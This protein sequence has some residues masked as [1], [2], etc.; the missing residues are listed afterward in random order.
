MEAEEL[1]KE[2]QSSEELLVPSITEA[3]VPTMKGLLRHVV[4]LKT[5][6]YSLN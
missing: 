4:G 5:S 6:A 3:G 2:E 1:A